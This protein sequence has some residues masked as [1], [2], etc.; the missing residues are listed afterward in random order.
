[1]REKKAKTQP[2]IWFGKKYYDYE[3][4]SILS[5]SQMQLKSFPLIFSISKYQL[6]YID[7]YRPT[8]GWQI[9]LHA[10]S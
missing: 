2:N 7:R 3:K 1:M 8:I 5:N 6:L 4:S 10:R 9:D